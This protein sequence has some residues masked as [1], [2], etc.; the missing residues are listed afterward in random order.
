MIP[1]TAGTNVLAVSLCLR[2]GT[3]RTVRPPGDR[4][5]IDLRA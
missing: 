3:E 1:E 4:I 5:S 2:E